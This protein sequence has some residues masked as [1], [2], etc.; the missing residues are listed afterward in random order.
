MTTFT[1]PPTAPSRSTMDQATFSAACEAWVAWEAVNA[2]EMSFFLSTNLVDYNTTSTTS[3]AIATGSKS[4]TVATGKLLQAGQYVIVAS[5]PSPAN[6]MVGQVTSYN[7]GTGAL[8]V[9]VLSIGGSGTL[10]A[11]TISLSPPWTGITLTGDATGSGTASFAVTI[12]ANA[13]AFAKFVAATAKGI[14]GAGAAGNF[15]QL[16]LANGLD[17]SGGNLIAA[18]L[19]PATVAA[20]GAITSSGGGVGYATGAGGTVTQATSKGTAV[21]LNT[22]GGQI[23]MNAA[24]LAANT[25]VW[26]TVNDSQVAASDVIALNLKSGPATAASYLYWIDSVAAGS[27]VIGVRNITVGS[28]SEALVLSFAVIKSVTS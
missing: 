7:S 23:T 16:G 5:T 3:V 11:W 25:S 21:T 18:N 22:L 1:L 17:V 15:Q 4:F 10:A 9:N 12:A 19:T 13:V 14:V 28:L 24:A 26:F 27:F 6:Y 20:T 8:V 2:T